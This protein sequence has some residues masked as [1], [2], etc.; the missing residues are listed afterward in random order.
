MYYH[1]CFGGV[2]IKRNTLYFLIS[3]FGIKTEDT[4]R[5]SY[6]IPKFICKFSFCI[7]ISIQFIH[8]TSSSVVLQY[9]KLCVPTQF[10]HFPSFLQSLTI[11]YY[12]Q[13]LK[14]LVTVTPS[15]MFHLME[16]SQFLCNS[17]NLVCLLFSCLL[18]SA[19]SLCVSSFL[20]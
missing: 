8:C 1:S 13:Q 7:F 10:G 20:F 9:F 6:P 16:T 14:H 11:G 15:N 5:G 18:A 17:F 4:Y 2:F 3:N 19:I 12:Q